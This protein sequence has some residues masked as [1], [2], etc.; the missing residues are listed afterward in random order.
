MI[1][2]TLDKVKGHHTYDL[3]QEQ[4]FKGEIRFN[5]E[6]KVSAQSQRFIEEIL[7]PI[8]GLRLQSVMFLDLDGPREAFDIR[9]HAYMADINWD[10][11]AAGRRAVSEAK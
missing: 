4:F 2:Q 10:D 8:Q 5:P 7:H 6:S 1:F 3:L 11:I 9:D